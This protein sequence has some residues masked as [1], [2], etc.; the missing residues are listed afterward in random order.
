MT[1]SDFL[2]AQGLD[3]VIRRYANQDERWT[4]SFSQ[5][6][7]SKGCLL[8]GIYGEGHDPGSAISNYLREV[9]GKKMKLSA[10]TE[11]RYFTVPKTVEFP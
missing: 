10:G 6:D 8:E 9:K 4:A 3:L 1:L 11:S 5:C 2:D 7:V